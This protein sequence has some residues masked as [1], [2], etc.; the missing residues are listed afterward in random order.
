[1]YY[2]KGLVCFVIHDTFKIFFS[3]DQKQ[4]KKFTFKLLTYYIK[5]EMYTYVTKYDRI[6][7]RIYERT[8]IFVYCSSGE[9]NYSADVNLWSF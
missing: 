9:C 7:E 2:L 8:K 1:M 4:D 6:Y 5:E 3:K